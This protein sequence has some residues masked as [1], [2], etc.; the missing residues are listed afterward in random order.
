MFIVLFHIFRWIMSF[1]MVHKSRILIRHCG[2]FD[3]EI[4]GYSKNGDN[5]NNNNNIAIGSRQLLHNP[6]SSA[7]DDMMICIQF[8]CHFIACLC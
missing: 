1:Q 3:V 6:R 8:I 4:R 2:I 5:N 7:L